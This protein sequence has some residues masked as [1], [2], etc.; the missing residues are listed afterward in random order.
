MLADLGY[1]AT[2][3]GRR[4]LFVAGP[5]PTLSGH[6]LPPRIGKFRDLRRGGNHSY[7]RAYTTLTY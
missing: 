7:A 1:T 6:P 3:L 4:L 2:I 5:L